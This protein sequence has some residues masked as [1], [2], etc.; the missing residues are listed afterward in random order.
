[1]VFKQLFRAGMELLRKICIPLALMVGLEN[2]AETAVVEPASGAV[3]LNLPGAL[4]AMVGE[5]KVRD[6]GSSRS[7]PMRLTRS[8]PH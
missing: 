5:W 3:R 2:D 6:I 1:M 4:N 8:C 7:H